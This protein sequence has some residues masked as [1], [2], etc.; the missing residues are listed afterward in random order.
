MKNT[1]LILLGVASLSACTEDRREPAAA[2]V[3]DQ[4][5][6][7]EYQVAPA[8]SV[9]WA[10]M[11]QRLVEGDITIEEAKLGTGPWCEYSVQLEPT[12]PQTDPDL[13]PQEQ[14]REPYLSAF[15][16]PRSMGF[17]FLITAFQARNTAPLCGQPET[18]LQGLDMASSE[19]S[20][21]GEWRPGAS[22]V[23][24]SRPE[25][26]DAWLGPPL[27]FS[28]RAG[29]QRLYFEHAVTSVSPQGYVQGEFRFMVASQGGRYVVLAR[30]G[31]F[32]MHNR[33]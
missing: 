4:F 7:F 21:S 15:G 9:D 24:A 22:L 33:R 19:G 20:A 26:R 32:G 3:R 23:A 1:V 16:H 29:D 11:S 17:T 30:N 6:T 8:G 10:R 27:E 13:V 25:M 14:T 28:D 31:K 5:L 2:P 18:T 12:P